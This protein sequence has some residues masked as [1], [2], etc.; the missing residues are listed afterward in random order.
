[1]TTGSTSWGQSFGVIETNARAFSGNWTGTGTISGSGDDEEINLNYGEYMISEIVNTGA[2]VVALRQNFYKTTGDDVSIYY[3]TAAT[4][5]GITSASWLLYGEQFT[6]LGYVQVK[7]YAGT[8]LAVSGTN[9]RYFVNTAGTAVFLSGSHTWDCGQDQGTG[10]FDWDGFLD[11]LV[12]WGHNFIRYWNWEQAKN[13]TGGPVVVNPTTTLTPEIWLRTGPGNAADGGLKFDLTQYNSTYFDRVRA[14]CIDAANHGL[15]VSVPLFQGFS[16]YLKGVGSNPWT[17][18]PFNINNN[19]NSIDGDTNDDNAGK[20]IQNDSIA[21][22]TTL[23]K[24]YVAH[25]IDVVNDLDNIFYEICNESDSGAAYEAWQDVMIDYIHTY[26]ASKQ[27]Q[28]AV[29]FTS[30]YPGGDNAV[31]LASDAEVI[32]PNADVTC[33]GTKV[34]IADTDHY[35]GIGGSADWAWKLLTSGVGGIAYMDSW[36]N[37]FIDGSGSGHPIQNFRDNLGYILALVNLSNLLGTIPQTGLAPCNTGYC[38]KPAS[39]S[40]H[41]FICYQPLSGSFILDLSAESGSFNIR[42]VNCVDGSI[43]TSQTETGGGNI[44][45]TQPIG[46]TSGWACLV[47]P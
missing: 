4:E 43:D 26:E 6:S 2:I 39:A 24:A 16:V 18:H 34:V 14:R 10:A 28:H 23:Q 44:V 40:Y 47:Y 8:P 31:L 1:M 37:T 27:K 17:Y 32:A 41:Q 13:I 33:D 38:L 3:R 35:Y 19:I 46:W 9:A 12:S 15:Y 42:K 29:W 5:G 22:V 20:E 7:L 25:L 36:D 30:T 21:A 11:D 45:V